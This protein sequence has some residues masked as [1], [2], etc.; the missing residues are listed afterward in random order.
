MNALPLFIGLTA[1]SAIAATVTVQYV[2]W[3]TARNLPE[4]SAHDRLHQY[5]T[6]CARLARKGWYSVLWCNAK[7]WNW[8]G[9]KA[10]SVFFLI[11]PKAKPAFVEKN[12]LAGLSDGPLSYYLKSLSDKEKAAK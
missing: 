6:A 4:I 9:S 5:G 3:R 10:Q 11:F 12:V 1:A 7:A 8:L 2:A